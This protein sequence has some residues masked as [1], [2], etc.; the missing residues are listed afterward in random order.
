MI[1]G[2]H[3]WRFDDLKKVSASVLSSDFSQVLCHYVVR[4]GGYGVCR[5]TALQL[6]E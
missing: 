4:Y 6:Y 2:L 1:A 3:L 5:R